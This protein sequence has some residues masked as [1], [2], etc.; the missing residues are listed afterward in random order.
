[1]TARHVI[2]S[3]LVQGV[4]FRPT[5]YRISTN[6]G[7]KGYVLNKGSEVEVVID[8]DSE[9]FINQVKQHLPAIAKITAIEQYSDDHTYDD[10]QIKH[11][12][13]GSRESPIPPDVATCAACRNELL[14]RGN[15]RN[16]FPFTNCTICG[17]R[18]SLITEVPYDRERTA[19]REFPLCS[20]CQNEYRDVEDRRYH[21]QTISCS[22]CGPQYMLFNDKK[23]KISST[24][25]IE[26]F[27]KEID[28][29]IEKRYQCLQMS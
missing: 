24:N 17:A 10:F 16:L 13:S 27:A 12:K 6:L 3:G 20:A 14:E 9:F 7:L 11:S 18:Y 19:M 21:A 25:I 4:G 5:I 8:K 22:K 29:L 26:D 2:F 1:M 15:R 23:Q 28:K